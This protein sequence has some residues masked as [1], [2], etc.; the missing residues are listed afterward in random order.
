MYLLCSSLCF[1]VLYASKTHILWFIKN[2]NKNKKTLGF[3]F[4]R[5]PHYV[6]EADLDLMILPSQSPTHLDCSCVLQ[7]LSEPF[8]AEMSVIHLYVKYN[9]SY[10]F[11]ASSHCC[12]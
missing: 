5:G 4:E 1:P 10:V 12:S 9:P 11:C 6:A 3:G 7:C 2:K 8:F